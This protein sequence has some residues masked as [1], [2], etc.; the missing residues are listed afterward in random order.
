MSD[1]TELVK[2]LRSTADR[3]SRF[4]YA[5]DECVRNLMQAADAIE[6]L[7]KDLERSK[8][9]KMFWE[10]EATEALKKF[11]VAVASTPRWIPVT[12]RLPLYEV[13][14]DLYLCYHVSG[15]YGQFS[16]VQIDWWDGEKFRFKKDGKHDHITHWMPLPEPPR[17][18]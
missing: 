4:G 12:E 15:K 7:Q 3:E 18:E 2:K 5:T 11:Q 10:K 9:Y 17:E 16:W 14:G 13:L 1:Y 6:E 8:E